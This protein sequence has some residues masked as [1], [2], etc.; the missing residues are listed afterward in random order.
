MFISNLYKN[1][2]FVST[3]IYIYYLFLNIYIRRRK[4]PI[5]AFPNPWHDQ[6]LYEKGNARFTALLCQSKPS[7]YPQLFICVAPKWFWPTKQNTSIISVS[8]M[9]TQI[10]IYY[11]AHETGI[12]FTAVCM[13]LGKNSFPSISPPGPSTTLSLR[14]IYDT[15]MINQRFNTFMINQPAF[16]GN[17][18]YFNFLP[19]WPELLY[20]GLA[21][22]KKLQWWIINC[23]Q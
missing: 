6:A 8:R 18:G 23:N 19:L 5:F 14:Q 21:E 1:L 10:R 16:S 9:H 17:V 3:C 7:C 15:F 11:K 22:I 2:I 12:C 4:F 20:F 13:S